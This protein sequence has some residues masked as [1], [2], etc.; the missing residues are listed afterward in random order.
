MASIMQAIANFFGG[1]AR[2]RA[3]DEAKK[4][5]EKAKREADKMMQSAREEASKI[6]DDARRDEKT[7]RGEVKDLE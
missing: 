2:K 3:A 4:E 6:I 1:G 7:R 5:L